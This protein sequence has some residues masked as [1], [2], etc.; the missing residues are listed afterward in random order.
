MTDTLHAAMA[1]VDASNVASVPERLRLAAKIYEERNKLYGDNYKHFGAAMIGLFPNGLSL[2]TA[3]DWTRMGMLIQIAAKV[4]RYAKNFERNGHK[5]SLDD[6]SVY[7][8]MLAEVDEEL[9][10]GK[11]GDG[12]QD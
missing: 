1:A 7:A 6:L 12:N 8:Q 5:D 11:V 2:K 3:D 10:E 9:A 4:T